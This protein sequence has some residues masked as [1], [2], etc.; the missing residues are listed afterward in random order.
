MCVLPE[1]E[2]VRRAVGEAIGQ[3][4]RDLYN[5]QVSEPVPGHMI[6][7]LRHLDTP[8]RRLVYPE[9]AVAPGTDQARK[10]L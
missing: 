6:G 4:I 10:H 7:L 8:E 3:A 2:R 1:D 5:R 9:Q